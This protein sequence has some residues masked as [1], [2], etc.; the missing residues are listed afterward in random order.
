MFSVSSRRMV[1]FLALVFGALA[2]VVVVGIT[3]LARTVPRFNQFILLVPVLKPFRYHPPEPP[4]PDDAQPLPPMEDRFRLAQR[5]IRLVEV[6]A[7]TNS[8][9][10][11]ET[12]QRP[13]LDQVGHPIPIATREFTGLPVQELT[14]LWDAQR[15]D[16]K[17]PRAMCFEPS[18]KLSFFNNEGTI[19]SVMLCWACHRASIMLDREGIQCVFDAKT[20]QATQLKQKLRALL[21][22]LSS[23]IEW[24]LP[25]TAEGNTSVERP[26][27]PLVFG[28]VTTSLPE[29]AALMQR[30]V[31]KHQ[32]QLAYCYERLRSGSSGINAQL[33]VEFDQAPYTP[34]MHRALVDRDAFARS[35]RHHTTEPGCWNSELTRLGKRGL[36]DVKIVSS[37][38]TDPVLTACV[39][40]SIRHWQL[41]RQPAPGPAPLHTRVPIL[42]RS[43]DL[44]PR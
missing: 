28:P 12:T 14:T 41:C 17:A 40:D 3:V 13:P 33:I 1:L 30:E 18:Y 31:Q 39:M 6:S 4:K 38:M 35:Q 20:P 16:C 19:L 34:E 44:V 8:E 29:A 25:P 2:S 21:P 27:P 36:Q 10:V 5:G 24:S 22:P 42:F 7:L 37:Q 15:L 23:S 43:P 32:R 11:F 9:L 26:D